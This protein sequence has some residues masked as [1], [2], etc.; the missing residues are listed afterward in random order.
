MELGWGRPQLVGRVAR[1]PATSTCCIM[2]HAAGRANCGSTCHGASTSNTREPV[3]DMLQNNEVTNN[4]KAHDQEESCLFIYFCGQLG[5]PSSC[6]KLED[7]SRTRACAMSATPAYHGLRPLTSTEASIAGGFGGMCSIAAGQ[8]L[9]VIKVLMQNEAHGP[10]VGA[11]RTAAMTF[12]TSGVQG[13]YAGL[14]LPLAGVVP[15]FAVMFGVYD[16][17]CK[18]LVRVGAT[19][20]LSCWWHC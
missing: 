19:K 8:P 20:K 4:G 13:L 11:F 2:Q 12:R 1:Q 6:L 5:T 10:G 17:A 18:K 16:A 3:R 9:D 7:A 14:L 15:I